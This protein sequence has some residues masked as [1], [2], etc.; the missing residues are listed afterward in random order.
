MKRSK[1]CQ[2]KLLD[3]TTTTHRYVNRNEVPGIVGAKHLDGF[4]YARRPRV[5]PA[6]AAQVPPNIDRNGHQRLAS[7]IRLTNKA[8]VH[9]NKSS[10]TTEKKPN[11]SIHEEKIIQM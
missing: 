10:K 4:G 6:Q 9:K 8:S 7:H 1:W 3:W 5:A 2:Q 11:L